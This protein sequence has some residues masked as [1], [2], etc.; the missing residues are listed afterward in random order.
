MTDDVLSRAFQRYL[1]VSQSGKRAISSVPGPLYHRKRFGRR[2]VNELSS[3][4]S[5]GSLPV[6]ALPNAPD[7]SRWQ[8]Q[9]PKPELWSTAPP[10]PPPVPAEGAL[11]PLKPPCPPE[12]PIVRKI[13]AVQFDVGNKSLPWSALKQQ[14]QDLHV[15]H[16]KT[17]GQYRAG[18]ECWSRTFAGVVSDGKISGPATADLC[19]AAH[20][21][22]EIAC[23]VFPE[24]RVLFGYFLSAIA[25]GMQTAKERDPSFCIPRSLF[26]EAFSKQLSHLEINTLTT[27]H[28]IFAMHNTHSR[29]R[30]RGL[31]IAYS[32]L[33][34]YFGLWRGITIHGEPHLWEWD[35]ISE[36]SQLA[37]IWSGRVDRLL[38]TIQ[39]DL[40]KGHA[41]IARINL[42]KAKRCVSRVERFALKKAA[43]MSDDGQLIQALAEALEQKNPKHHSV[44]YRQATRLLGK[45]EG[46]SRVRYNWLQV[47]ARLPKIR[48]PQFQRLLDLFPSRG[49]AALSHTELCHLMLLHW[50]SQRFLQDAA[51]TRRRWKEI[52]GRKSDNSLASLALAVNQTNPPE[53]CTRIFWNL[54][55]ILRR[56]AGKK[57]LL[58]QLGCL[59]AQHKFSPMFLQRLAWT[60]N[61]IRTA[62]LI[63]H[64]LSRNRG[65]KYKFWWPFWGKFSG[66]ISEKWKWPLIN[67]LLVSK[68]F[69]TPYSDRQH[70]EQYVGDLLNQELEQ[71]YR[72][73]LRVVEQETPD[74]H[75]TSYYPITSDPTAKQWIPQVRRLK[76]SLHLLRHAQQITDRQALHYV[77]IFTSIL[78]KKQGFISARDLSTLTS[79]IMRTLK[80]GQPGSLRRFSWY[81]DVICR[82]L[83]EKAAAKVGMILKSRRQ[84]NWRFW[85]MRLTITK[86]KQQVKARDITRNLRGCTK[87]NR[88]E[89]AILWSTILY[90]GRYRTMKRRRLARLKQSALEMHQQPET[91][92]STLDIDVLARPQP[93]SGI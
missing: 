66:Q 15:G 21:H 71:D 74:E 70:V 34:R 8:W 37:S 77:T 1:A 49:H 17:A 48:T 23:L 91:K 18:F 68:Q 88:K 11:R 75:L 85:Q 16:F 6:W 47:L 14:L 19:M 87:S 7:L 26:W 28:T 50:S 4:Q 51:K 58:R 69:N 56:R 67:P 41:R 80:Q 83:G 76:S 36:A 81:V 25:G 22:I 10:P 78:A 33:E 54:W 45:T 92:L 24:L 59:S 65:E 64:I 55:A 42:D 32:H 20:R 62:L 72:Q 2:H 31:E 46:W 52:Q 35:A 12:A 27:K 43:L 53:Q 73:Q 86:H 82:H 79:V 63:H 60:S 9:P 29:H 61:D 39:S 30:R 38:T 40:T 57:T 5:L 13:R 90:D 89:M 84:A 3:F 44:F 93:A